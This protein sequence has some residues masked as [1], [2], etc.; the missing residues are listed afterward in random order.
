MKRQVDGTVKSECTVC[1]SSKKGISVEVEYS[2][3]GG[4]NIQHVEGKRAIQTSF[5]DSYRV[6]DFCTRKCFF[7]WASQKV[8][9]LSTELFPKK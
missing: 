5:I 1:K 6:L 9:F 7:N 2:V 3:Y 4:L 8:E